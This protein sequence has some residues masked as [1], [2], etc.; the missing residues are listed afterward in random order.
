VPEFLKQIENSLELEAFTVLAI[1][2]TVA[3]VLNHTNQ[4]ALLASSLAKEAIFVVESLVEQQG[5]KPTLRQ[6]LKSYS[7]LKIKQ[8]KK[9]QKQLQSE[10][11]ILEQ[12]GKKDEI[13]SMRSEFA[14]VS[15]EI[16]FWEK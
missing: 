6:L 15:K 16:V 9:K 2:E 8:L 13:L 4:E 7:L 11:G 3:E 5:Q 14:K 10:L 1:R 12:S